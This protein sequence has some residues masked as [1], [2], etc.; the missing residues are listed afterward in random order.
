MPLRLRIL[1]AAAKRGRQLLLGL[2]GLLLA[3]RAQAQREYYNWYFG[4]RAG[5]TFLTGPQALADGTLSFTNAALACL[6]D[7]AGSYQFTTNGQQVWDRTGQVMAGGSNIGTI[8][9]A[10]GGTVLA[11]PQPGPPGRYY[12]FTNV[13]WVNKDFKP[14]RPLSG[15]GDQ[16]AGLPRPGP[17]HAAASR[18]RPGAPQRDYA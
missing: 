17:H 14:A 4:E 10:A 1:R 13:N 15:R 12:I 5:L 9:G 8:Y 3:Q 11:V 6:S 18:L 7:K 2:L 16:R